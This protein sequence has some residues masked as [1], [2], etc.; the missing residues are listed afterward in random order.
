MLR[1]VA[2]FVDGDNVNAGFSRD[3]IHIGESYGGISLAKVFGGSA[4]LKNWESCAQFQFI[5]SGSG[6]NA[7]DLHLAIEA[8]KFSLTQ[9]V[10]V[11]LL[12]SSDSDFIHLAR[13]LR[14]RGIEVVGCGEEKASDSF[15]SA[16]SDF[17]NLGPNTEQ[18][19]TAVETF[20]VSDM[21]LRIKSV[22]AAN[23]NKGMGMR[24]AD[25]SPVMYSKFGTRI[26]HLPERT[27]RGYLSGRKALF[28]IDPR[29]ANAMVRFIPEGFQGTNNGH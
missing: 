14:E 5:Y 13:C 8:T 3:I 22:I 19:I 7:A 2:I 28:N 9:P 11:V 4:S 27:W 12:C 23:S 25:L 17:R 21:D 15:R 10:D 29:G 1:R 16:C 6:K 24:I 26:S 18:E 20:K